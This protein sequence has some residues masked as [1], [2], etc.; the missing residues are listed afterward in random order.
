MQ[1]A[2]ANSEVATPPEG[3]EL[4]ETPWGVQMFQRIA[5][6]CEI[7]GGLTGYYMNVDGACLEAATAT[8]LQH[9]LGTIPPMRSGWELL[10][11][12]EN[13]G[14][15]YNPAD[16]PQYGCLSIGVTAAT[17]YLDGEPAAHTVVLNGDDL[18]FNPASRFL[19]LD[20][21]PTSTQSGTA[22]MPIMETI[23]LKEKTR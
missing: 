9:P 5:S 23:T 6:T 10:M 21:T 20:G 11:W 22:A 1:K 17:P 12:A 8:L 2:P 4:V 14:L 18:I 7:A 3:Y 16:G 19:W 15:R 13:E